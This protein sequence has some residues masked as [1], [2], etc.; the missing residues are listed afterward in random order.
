[1]ANKRDKSDCRDPMD[2]AC[3]LS[4]I[5]S[6]LIVLF[7]SLDLRVGF[8]K[9]SP[10]K[11][12]SER[13]LQKFGIFAYISYDD[14]SPFSLLAIELEKRPWRIQWT[15]GLTGQGVKEGLDWLSRALAGQ[16]EVI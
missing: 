5:L 2:I 11:T 16:A 6:T 3:S 8:G 7:I 12:E 13:N 1:M 15:S 14:R 10:P 9:K 4:M